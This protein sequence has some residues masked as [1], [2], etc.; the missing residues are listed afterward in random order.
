MNATLNTDE[1]TCQQNRNI[2]SLGNGYCKELEELDSEND[3]QNLAFSNE[4]LVA[5]KKIT[6][7][8]LL[9]GTCSYRRTSYLNPNS[10]FF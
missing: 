6:T 2:F 9:L 1:M 5:Q 10:Q 7:I 4:A 3:L 8:K